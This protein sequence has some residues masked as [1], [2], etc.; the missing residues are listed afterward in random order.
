[1]SNKKVDFNINKKYQ[2]IYADP[3]WKFKVWCYGSGSGRSPDNHYNTMELE[4]ICNLPISEISAKNCILFIWGTWP[5]LKECLSVIEAWGFEYKTD[6]F[7]W[8]KQNKSGNGMFCG[9][10]YW[11]RKNTEF[12]LLATKGSPKRIDKSV[13][14]LIISPRG[15]HSEKPNE[16]RE[17]IVQLVGDLPR[18]ELFAREEVEGWDA[19]GDEIENGFS[20]N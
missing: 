3:P 8:A 13:R 20:E 11:T 16:V 1:M 15:R 18:I 14:E 7:L 12:V 9:L 4:D 6:A 2:I 10:G 5:K 19:W 17:R